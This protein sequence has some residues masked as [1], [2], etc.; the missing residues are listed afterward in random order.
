MIYTLPGQKTLQDL[1]SAGYKKEK[2]T[3]AA[4]NVYQNGIYYSKELL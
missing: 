1:F 4:L 3:C 2:A